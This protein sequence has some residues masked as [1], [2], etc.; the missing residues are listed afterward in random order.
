MSVTY[1]IQIPTN[2]ENT[3]YN[4]EREKERKKERKGKFHSNRSLWF[5]H[6]EI[7]SVFADSAMQFLSNNYK[8]DAFCDSCFIRDCFQ[9]IKLK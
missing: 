3:T 5:P 1:T 9:A 6:F 2:P 7:I 4:I 8:F